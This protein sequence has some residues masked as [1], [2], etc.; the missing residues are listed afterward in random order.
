MKIAI[1]IVRSKEWIAEARLKTGENVP[2]DVSVEIDVASLSEASR[3]VILKAGGGRY[4]DFKKLNHDRDYDIEPYG[5]YGSIPLRAN[6]SEPTAADVDLAIAN[7]LAEL[8]EEK[9]AKE[10]ADAE[11]LAQQEAERIAKEAD[12]AAKA[13]ARELL[14]DEIAAKDR[15]IVKLKLE[16]ANYDNDDR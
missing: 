12:N 14:A 2:E 6:V 10:K 4:Y 16:L 7:A 1:T 3:A 5:S 8:A 13:A 15:E 11:R 9:A